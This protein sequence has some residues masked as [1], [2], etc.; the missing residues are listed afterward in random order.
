MEQAVHIL[1]RQAA[2]TRDGA[3]DGVRRMVTRRASTPRPSPP[4]EERE[5]SSRGGVP[6][7]ALGLGRQPPGGTRSNAEGS[8]L[9]Q[10][11]QMARTG[12][13]GQTCDLRFTI[14]EPGEGNGGGTGEF[15]PRMDT[16]CKPESDTH[17]I[18]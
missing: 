18:A 3:F 6:G 7:A 10:I 9:P 1:A 14:Y 8:F 5:M 17:K 12:S 2:S 15:L 4:G 16:V 11:A 13:G